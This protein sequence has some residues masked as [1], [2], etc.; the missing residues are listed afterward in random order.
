MPPF[1]YYGGKSRLAD[2]IVDI[3]PAHQHYV[4]PY[5]GG[6]SVLLAK[7]PTRFE[8]VN[9]LDG[10]LMHFWRTLRD[11]PEEMARVCALTPHSR[12]EHAA[13]L[14]RPDDMD[15]VERARRIWV[16]LSQGRSGRIGQTG[17]RFH[18]STKGS[19][20]GMP[21]YL[22]AYVQRIAPVAER[23][24]GVSL[25]CRPALDL[26]RDYGQHPDVCLYVDPPYSGDTGRVVGYEHEMR[27][28]AEHRDLADALRA[29]KA[30]VV[31]SGYHGPLYDALYDDWE[32][33]E[34]A[35]MTGQAHVRSPRTEV[36]WSNRAI[37]R[38]LFSED[39]A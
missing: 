7:S 17:W 9:D 8:T 32:R 33:V 5:G 10:D 19:T 25:E 16:R 13:A 38:H 11:Q 37:G 20:Y 36:L 21:Q 18:M 2:R 6:L 26:I 29:C 4:E 34:I 30:G 23:L 3:L 12:A 28:E 27:G 14:D 1:T 15:P 22:D 24:R 31:L 39:I 35:T